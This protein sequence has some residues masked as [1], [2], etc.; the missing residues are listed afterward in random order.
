MKA[1]NTFEINAKLA[2][3]E[4]WEVQ[5]NAI[6]TSFEFE[7]FKEAFTVMTRIAFECE[8]QGH[9][10]EWTNIYNTLHIR[11]STHDAD[12]ITEKDFVL[13]KTIEN[14]IDSQ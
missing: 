13:A 7:N 14:I 8:L 10:P 3:L 9:H 12:G 6:A 11:L 4:G 2:E 5:D 1:L